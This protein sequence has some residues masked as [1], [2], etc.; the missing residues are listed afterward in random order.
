[1][2]PGVKPTGRRVEI[3]LIAVVRFVAGKVANEHIYWNQASVLVQVGLLDSMGLP[4]VGVETERKVE[5]DTRSSNE[6]MPRWADSGN[7]RI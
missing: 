3:P 4:V 5:D 1:M 6:V 7:E 2:L